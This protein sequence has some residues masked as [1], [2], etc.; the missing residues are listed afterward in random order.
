MQSGKLS[1]YYKTAR[2]AANKYFIVEQEREGWS[3]T[4]RVVK[5]GT[6]QRVMR[7]PGG[8]LELDCC[9]GISELSFLDMDDTLA[10]QYKGAKFDSLVALCLSAQLINEDNRVYIVGIPVK[11]INDD[12]SIY[13]FN[14]YKQ[15][16]KTLLKFGFKK[17]NARS[18]INANSSNK[19]YVLTVQRR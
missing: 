16:L 18:Y 3:T 6:S 14:F 17:V 12:T 13:D 15:L 7:L 5:K 8:P 10:K 1:A 11:K 9:C 4:K 19:L 2:K